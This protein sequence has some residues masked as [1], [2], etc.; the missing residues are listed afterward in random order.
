MGRLQIM[1]DPPDTD[2]ADQDP[3]ERGMRRRS[4]SP[5]TGLWLVLGGVVMLG[6]LVYVV[7]ALI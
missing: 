2:P 1:A 6:A 3:R 5:E 7:S 4:G